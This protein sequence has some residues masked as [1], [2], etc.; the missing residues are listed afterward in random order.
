VKPWEHY[1][2]RTAELLGQL[3]FT[4]KVNDPLRAPNGVV[5]RVDVSARMVVAGVPMLW[6]TE[7]KLWNR[8]VTKEKVSALKDIVN[9]LGADR[10][11]LVSEKGFQSGAVRLAAAKNI[12]LSSL[13]ELRANAAKQV[14][15]TEGA[16]I[17]LWS[18]MRVLM[19]FRHVPR[20]V[21]IPEEERA[22][23]AQ[24]PEAT[25]YLD[26][27][28]EIAKRKGYY[29][30]DEERMRSIFTVTGACG[31]WNEGMSAATINEA[32]SMSL[33]VM[34]AL[35][36]A[37]IDNWPVPFETPDGPKLAWSI[38]QLLDLVG[39]AITQLA[40]RVFDE[41]EKLFPAELKSAI[42]VLRRALSLELP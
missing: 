38:P 13:D 26:A 24:R 3:G 23:F 19:R 12:T 27:L 16:E 4:T 5:H 40:E 35:D 29:D 30:G 36:R 20:W 10:G 18:I 11:L 21:K 33:Q 25:D 1:Q 37:K 7:C 6:V 14:I 8:A 2:Y 9:D 15:S 17:R 34:A 28:I 22:E 31:V 39:P 32:T 41:Y 42:G